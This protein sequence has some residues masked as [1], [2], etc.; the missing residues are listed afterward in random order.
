[1]G[2]RCPGGRVSKATPCRD[3]VVR[4]L[5]EDW[6]L[7]QAPKASA[8]PLELQCRLVRA[9]IPKPRAW[10]IY[11]QG[12]CV[13]ATTGCTAQALEQPRVNSCPPPPPALSVSPP[14]TAPP[15]SSPSLKHG[16]PRPSPGAAGSLAFPSGRMA[17]R[18]SRHR[19]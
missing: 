9:F 3:F 10:S 17:L 18:V 4:G 13:S 11:C 16:Q 15:R 14:C 6:S 7:R 12:V 2:C 8:G 1:M 19:H 5:R